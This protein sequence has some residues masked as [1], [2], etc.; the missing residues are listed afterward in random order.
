MSV[1]AL[2]GFEDP[3]YPYGDTGTIQRGWAIMAGGA[4][5]MAKVLLNLAEHSKSDY[6]K[7]QAAVAV[8]D[9]VGLTG[10]PDISINVLGDANIAEQQET[11]TKLVIARLD[12]LAAADQVIDGSVVQDD[13][14]PED[15]FD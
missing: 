9:R 13:A 12:A 1:A 6:V 2:D 4:E 7:V 14:E 5:R 8:L 3:D 15:M 10:Q 11:A